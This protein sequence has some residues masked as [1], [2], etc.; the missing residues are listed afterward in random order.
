MAQYYQRAQQIQRT[1]QDVENDIAIVVALYLRQLWPLIFIR[2]RDNRTAEIN[3]AID[4]WQADFEAGL[5]DAMIAGAARMVT[6]EQGL[7]SAAG[8]DIQLNADQIVA[9]YEA[10]VAANIGRGQ[11]PAGLIA[12]STKRQIQQ[13]LADGA[14][15]DE[16]RHLFDQA[17]ADNIAGDQTAELLSATTLAA[18]TLAGAGRWKWQTREDADVCQACDDLHGQTFGRLDPYPPLHP[19]CRCDA[20]PIM[21]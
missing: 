15:P 4:Q 11:G 7:W 3:A 9:D 13:A 12:D 20:V 10:Q 16:I 5:R 18:M 8:K 19:N 17:R 21:D 2:F 6:T 1:R 14:S